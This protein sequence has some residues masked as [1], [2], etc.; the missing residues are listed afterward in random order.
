MQVYHIT[1]HVL[2][3]MLHSFL[4]HVTDLITFTFLCSLSF[5]NRL[6]LEVYFISGWLHHRR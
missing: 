5:V 2:C 6:S 3:V 4:I 1:V